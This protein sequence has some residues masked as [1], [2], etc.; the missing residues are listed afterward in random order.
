MRKNIKIVISAL[1]VLGV[2]LSSNVSVLALGKNDS[3]KEKTSTAEFDEK[4]FR[5]ELKEYIKNIDVNVSFN[6]LETNALYQDLPKNENAISFYKEIERYKKENPKESVE[7]VIKHFDESTSGQGELNVLYTV[8]E[9]WSNLTTSEKLLVASSPA[10]AALTVMCRAKAYTLTQQ[11]MGKNGL[12][13]PS[14]AFRHAIWNALMCKYISKA[15]AYL[16]ATAHE[17]KTAAQLAQIAPDGYKES[18]HRTMDLYNN[19]KGRDCWNI[20]TDSILWTTDATLVTRVKTKLN[21]K[22]LTWLHS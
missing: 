8:Y 17:D 16:M 20:L 3:G 21:N 5:K 18:Q 22:E 6:D 11:N 9:E 2:L 12:G 19:Q 14:D 10:N 7:Q 15:W 1:L 4:L 13:D